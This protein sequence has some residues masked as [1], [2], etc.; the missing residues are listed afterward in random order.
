MSVISCAQDKKTK[1]K[2]VQTE[3][4]EG[5]NPEVTIKVNKKYDT[6]GNLI[7][8]DSTYSYFYTA[9]GRD[10]VKVG[11]DTAIRRFKSLYNEKFSAILDESFN[12]TF[13]NDSL[14]KYD[15]FNEDYFSK[16]F[17]LNKQ[18]MDEMLFRM[19]SLK[20]SFFNDEQI[21]KPGMKKP[22]D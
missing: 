12:E 19:D 16:R 13:L 21:K 7:K 8:L 11:L 14:F 20:N 10:S 15:F 17:E 2:T 6:K 22:Q 18:K 1:P 9:K 3:K 4:K 5:D